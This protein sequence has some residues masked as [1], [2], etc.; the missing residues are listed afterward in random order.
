TVAVRNWPS[1]L[2]HFT[3]EFADRMPNN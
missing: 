2:S 1:A 3:I